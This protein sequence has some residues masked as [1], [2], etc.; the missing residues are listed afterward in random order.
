M[1][2]LILPKELAEKIFIDV[3]QKAP[4][5]AC[6]VLGGRIE[7]EKSIVVTV[8]VCRNVSNKPKVTYSIAPEDLANAFTDIDSKGLEILG[9]YHSHPFGRVRPSETDKNGVTWHNEFYVIS[10]LKKEITAWKWD[11]HQRDFIEGEIVIIES[12]VFEEEK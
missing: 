8:Y 9:F 10:N 4:E 11:K 2:Q 12:P 5:E 1:A 7:G 3:K 6:G